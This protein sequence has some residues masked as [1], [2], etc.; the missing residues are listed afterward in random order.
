MIHIAI[1]NA[2][3]ALHDTEVEAAV[4]GLQRQISG[5]FAAAWG[6][7]AH[8]SFVAHGA[9]LPSDQWWLAVLDDSDQQGAL[10]Y[11]D[12]TT[13]GLPLGKVF[14]ATDQKYGK[15]WTV[16]ASH[17]LLEMLADPDID[18]AAFV[19]QK[20]SVAR[21]Y[22]YEVCDPVEADEL[23]Y[24]VDGVRVSGFVYPAWFQSF[25][26]RGSTRFDHAGHLTQPFEL[27]PGGYCSVYD[28]TGGSWRQVTRDGDEPRFGHR[29]RP[30]SRR[31]RRR[32]PRSE[33]LSSTVFAGPPQPC[34]RCRPLAVAS[35]ATI[36]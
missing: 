8:L 19:E 15:Q 36:A 13:D 2:S 22:A 11:H 9:T 27:A 10:G 31:E 25:R 17:E 16:T 1:V 26:R 3:S 14:A 28:V 4:G 20:S 34:A 29:P 24:D 5:D 32:T 6:V 18:L 12:L 21:L 23:A 7:D 35:T 33:W 30:G